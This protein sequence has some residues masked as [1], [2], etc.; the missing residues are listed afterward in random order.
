MRAVFCP[1]PISCFRLLKACVYVE[2]RRKKIEGDRE[3]ETDI[4]K[5]TTVVNR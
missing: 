2:G 4:E 3:R 1:S 5:S